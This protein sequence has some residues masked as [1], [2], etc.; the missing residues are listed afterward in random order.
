MIALFF[1]VIPRPEHESTYFEMAAKLKPALDA[2]GGLLFLDRSRSAAR[3]GWFLSH[4]FWQDE[5]SMARWRA[6]AAHHR[7]QACGRAD[8]LSD[9]RLRVGQVIASVSA[10]SPL[11][12]A[13]LTPETAYN[14]PARV[15]ERF[16]VSIL[17]NGGVPGIDG[18]C[19][20]SVYD[21]TL[22]VQVATASS[23][24]EGCEMVSRAASHPTI[25]H[26]RLCLVSRDYSL[27]DRREAPQFFAPVSL[28]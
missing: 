26:A 27:H 2:S 19:F 16:M 6:N 13:V 3:P 20:T 22:T 14:D 7:V 5:A 25:K 10:G 1:E 23:S 8:V 18:E 4:Q 11:A 28:A 12:H 9:Y 24:E 17:S 21:P 15:P